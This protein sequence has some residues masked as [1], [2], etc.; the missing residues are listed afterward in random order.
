MVEGVTINLQLEIEKTNQSFSRWA[1]QTNDWLET[2]E[3]KLRQNMEEYACTIS[4]LKDRDAEL[5]GGRDLHF[6]LKAQQ[7]DEIGRYLASIEKLKEHQ[8]GLE[9]QVHTCEVDEGREERRLE[10]TRSEHEIVRQKYEQSVKDITQGLQLFKMLGLEFQKSEG[11]CMK[12][13]FTQIDRRSP[14]REFYFLI[15]V[16]SNDKY[17]LVETCPALESGKSILL[18]RELNTD[19]DMGKFVFKMRK[20]FS[21]LV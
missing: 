16:D 6:D 20:E 9:L 4:A 21:S 1:T 8:K 13:V 15:F 3:N 11:E 7:H 18:L 2:S 17:N 5:E 19:N 12:F 10:L 14:S